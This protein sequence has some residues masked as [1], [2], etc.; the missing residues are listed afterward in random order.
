MKK[1]SSTKPQTTAKSVDEYLA[2]IPQ[3]ARGTLNI[4]RAAIRSVVPEEATETISYGIPMFK[5]KGPAPRLRR[6]FKAL[7]FVPDEYGRDQDVQERT[8]GLRDIQRHD[9]LPSGHA[10]ASS[11]R[12]E[13]GEGAPG[14]KAAQALTPASPV[15]LELDSAAEFHIGL[16]TY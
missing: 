7:Q 2:R 1:A 5:Y 15:S 9:P 6:I 12:E 8:E 13:N 4:V 14:R 16:L 10:S 11:S 3:P